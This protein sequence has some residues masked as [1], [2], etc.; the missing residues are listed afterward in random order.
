MSKNKITITHEK[1]TIIFDGW[2]KSSNGKP[3]SLGE[4]AQHYSKHPL[5]KDPITNVRDHHK[6]LS[7]KISNPKNYNFKDGSKYTHM[8]T[9]NPDPRFHTKWND[10]LFLKENFRQFLMRQAT[11][12]K[13]YVFVMEYGK[14]K[15]HFHGL[16]S[17]TIV[18][19]N[20]FKQNIISHYCTRTAYHQFTAVV[21]RIADHALQLPCHVQWQGE[22][23]DTLPDVKKYGPKNKGYPYLRKERDNLLKPLYQKNI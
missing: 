1:T 3:P 16:I 11:K 21:Q 4:A 5:A 10:P 8:V 22:E 6:L 12:I 23:N 14:G 13:S 20:E 9:I 7:K 18:I 2:S 17:S 19:A 15:F